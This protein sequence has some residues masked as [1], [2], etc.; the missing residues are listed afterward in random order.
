MIHLNNTIMKFIRNRKRPISHFLLFSLLFF[1][2]L[3]S[4]SLQATPPP[5]S[6]NIKIGLMLDT[7]SSMNGLIDQAK[8]QLWKIVNELAEAR[9]D[10]TKPNIM[11]GLYEYGN[12]G[13]SAEGGYI[14]LVTPLTTDLDRVSQ[15]LFSL[16][17]NG[18]S[19][20]CGQVIKKGTDEL[21]WGN[22]SDDLKLIFIAGNEAFTQGPVPFRE[23]CNNAAEHGITINT[24]FCGNFEQ[25]IN[26]QW[27]SGADLTGGS[28]M[29]IQQN[30]KTTY[31]K[32]PYDDQISGLNNDLNSTYIYYGHEGKTKKMNQVKQDANSMHYGQSNSVSRIVSKSS[33]AY[34][35]ESWDMVD[36][37]CQK[38]FDIGK[39]DNKYL[40][41][42]MQDMSKEEKLA[43]VN[44]QKA[45]RTEIKN[46]IKD[47]NVERTT[48][49]AKKKKALGAAAAAS[50]DAAM[51]LAIKKQAKAKRFIFTNDK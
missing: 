15:D 45:K 12:S 2:G 8:S 23:A 5:E 46:K 27:K 38:D 39:I 42:N 17:T 25:G 32:S 43:Y 30:Q 20:H 3:S 24:I 37:S 10:G 26:T 48:F 41:K 40:P 22:S 6:K 34:R 28:Y 31:I 33:H 16:T 14:R 13:L 44:E 1:V 36:K 19:E 51:L 29:S 47:L 49:I 35:N 4:T 7:S 50:L 9:C 21:A 18:G 11:I